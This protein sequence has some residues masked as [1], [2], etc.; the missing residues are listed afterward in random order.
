MAWFPYSFMITCNNLSQ[1]VFAI[2]MLTALKL[3]SQI[4]ST[5]DKWRP[6]F[7]A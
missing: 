1:E 2:D 4:Y 7:K 5:I 3:F 6:G